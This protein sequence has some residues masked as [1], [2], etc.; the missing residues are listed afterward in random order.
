MTDTSPLAIASALAAQLNAAGGNFTARAATGS[1]DVI[2]VPESDAA[3]AGGLLLPPV[4]SDAA[5][6]AAAKALAEKLKATL[7]ARTGVLT[8]VAQKTPKTADAATLASDIE[9]ILAGIDA[10]EKGADGLKVM[11]DPPG[12]FFDYA[13]LAQRPESLAVELLYLVPPEKVGLTTAGASE[14][15]LALVLPNDV[16]KGVRA[17]SVKITA[18]DK[19]MHT[20]WAV[21]KKDSGWTFQ[22]F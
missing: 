22:P 1:A 3:N 20:W 9:K 18:D 10:S 16:R 5:A 11:R 14:H 13:S 7:G 6:D 15:W 12:S 17:I 4:A 21:P 8:L 2:L 19:L